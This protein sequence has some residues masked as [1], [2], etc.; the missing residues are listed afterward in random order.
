[1]NLL[2]LRIFSSVIEKG[3]FAEAAKENHCSPSAVSFHIKTLENYLQVQ[4]FEKTGR[5]MRPTEQARLILPD[6]KNILTSFSSIEK[7]K[8]TRKDLVGK[9]RIGL[10]DSLLPESIA[11]IFQKFKQLAPNVTIIA[12][13]SDTA[14]AL[15]E[16][17][18]KNELDLAVSFNCGD[19]PNTLSTYPLD[20][21]LLA[22]L[23]GAESSIDNSAFK[24]PGSKIRLP[25]I[26]INLM[27]GPS[28]F[29]DRYLA[30]MNI[31]VEGHMQVNSYQAMSALLKNNIGFAYSP[32]PIFKQEL[33]NGSIKILPSFLKNIDLGIILLKN[34]TRSE[35]PAVSLMSKLIIGNLSNPSLDRE[36]FIEKTCLMKRKNFLDSPDVF[37]FIPFDCSPDL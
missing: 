20:S 36:H 14:Y 3:N 15:R 26:S 24:I 6:V 19:Y 27:S 13:G 30:R 33:E 32:V 37:D 25:F 10:A 11:V 9:I 5:C 1:M 34:K 18:Y 21:Y 16:K 2:T 23:C 35:S 28:K 8:D 17:V 4:L 29:F 12:E 22:I 31:T 7:L